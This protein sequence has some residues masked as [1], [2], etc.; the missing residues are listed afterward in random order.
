MINRRTGEIA[1]PEIRGFCLCFLDASIV[2][3]QFVIAYF[4]PLNAVNGSLI[5]RGT[6]VIDGEWSF[7]SLILMEYFFAV[8]LF[9]MYPFFPESPYF[10]IKKGKPDE[11]RKSLNKIH[12]AQ[13]QNFISV[14]FDRIEK[15][16]KFSD[17]LARIAAANG[18]PYYQLFRGTNLVASPL[19]RIIIGRGA[20]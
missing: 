5:S 20:R 2:F 13:D 10:L 8:L 14:E 9:V 3:G 6:S 16:V 12:G 7:K 11:A 19:E 17:E 1:R 15:N 18:P 4:F